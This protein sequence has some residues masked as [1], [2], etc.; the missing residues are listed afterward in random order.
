MTPWINCL[1]EAWGKYKFA[2]NIL[3]CI[4]APVFKNLSE[5]EKS[6]LASVL[7]EELFEENEVIVRQGT[8]GNTFYIIRDGRVKVTEF[9]KATKV[10]ELYNFI[11]FNTI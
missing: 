10:C 8:V 1:R 3:I 2:N 11:P 5:Y 9:D 7:E 4:D 6:K